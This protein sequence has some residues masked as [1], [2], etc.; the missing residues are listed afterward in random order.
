LT[1]LT[2]LTWDHP[3]G[4]QPLEACAQRWRQLEPDVT[5]R[6]E[7][8]SLKS[9][10][11]DPVDAAAGRYDLVVVDHPFVG[12]I[13]EQRCYL[14]LDRRLD[15]AVLARSAD[16]VGASQDS[17]RFAGR[18]WAL[19][20]DAAAHVSV[21]RADGLAGGDVPRTWEQVQDTALVLGPDRFVLA[22]APVDC[23]MLL[24][25]VAASL[26]TPVFAAGAVA[27]AD[28][29]AAALELIAGLA[30]MA[31]PASLR[32][33][34]IAV[35]DMM[36]APAG[37]AYCPALFGYSNFA[38]APGTARLRFAA[39]PAG[40][41]G[42]RGVLGG[43]GLAVSASSSS[44]E[45]A[46]RFAA[47]VADPDTQAT[48]YL[49]AGGQPAHRAAWESSEAQRVAPG[50]FTDTLAALDQSW[51]RPRWAGFPVA[52]KDA[53]D[54][55][56]AY[57]SAGARRDTTALVGQLQLLL[58]GAKQRASDVPKPKYAQ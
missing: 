14:P 35:L 25:T 52:Q 36:S 55:I 20:I 41:G 37:P 26:G 58:E 21:R 24:L 1:I 2:G 31:H 18:Q 42:A 23:M 46:V 16:T 49:R 44:P 39:V 34:P 32:F 54:S 17:Y 11:D 48:T 33:N 3:R 5:V 56:H 38:R 13:A 27:A 53:A 12:T 29:L 50:Y 45:A 6:W 40:A 57:L 7:R 22:L 51:V 8:R 10:G 28:D 15:P 47:F 19:A 30:D 4:Y 43:A 9:F